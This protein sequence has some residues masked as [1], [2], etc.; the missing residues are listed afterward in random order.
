MCLAREEDLRAYR[1]RRIIK[2][3]H[4]TQKHTN[5][6]IGL[7]LLHT[8]TNVGQQTQTIKKRAQGWDE[9]NAT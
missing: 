6:V 8:V 4:E 5:C 1:Y 7:G 2:P 9:N 3:Q